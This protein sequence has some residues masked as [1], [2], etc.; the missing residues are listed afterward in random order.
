MTDKRNIKELATAA[1]RLLDTTSEER[2]DPRTWFGRVDALKLA[3]KVARGEI[4]H[5]ADLSGALAQGAQM[6]E[7]LEAAY[8]ELKEHDAD[9]Q[10]RTPVSVNNLIVGA[11]ASPLP[12]THSRCPKCGCE[13]KGEAAL[14]SG[15]VWCH[16]CADGVA[17]SS[18]DRGSK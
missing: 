8:H 9:Y 3:I 5:G 12:S 1:E 6:R 15:E 17:V 16:P 10:Y 11:L 2:N 7:A 13:T 4:P 18:T 14:V